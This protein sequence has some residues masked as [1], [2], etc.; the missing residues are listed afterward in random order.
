[1]QLNYDANGTRL[2]PEAQLALPRWP[3]FKKYVA[4]DFISRTDVHSESYRLVCPV[5]TLL[6]NPTDADHESVF[7]RNQREIFIDL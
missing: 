4:G 1:M 6:H 2:S 7:I 5:K 3:K